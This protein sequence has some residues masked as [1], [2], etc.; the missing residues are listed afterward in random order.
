MKRFLRGMMVAAAL[1][2][3]MG[4]VANDARAANAVYDTI[5][6]KAEWLNTSRALTPEDLKG[7]IILLDFWTF[8]CINCMHVIPDLHYLEEKFGNKLTVIGV[9]SAKFT[10]E[11]DS[12]NIRNAM[13]RYDIHHPVVNDHDFGIWRAMGAQAWPTFM[14]I[15]PDGTIEQTYAGEGHREDLEED[16]QDLVVDAG[17]GLRVD[18]LPIALEKDE[19]PKTVLRF[20]GK[21]ELAP[22]FGG[23]PMLFVA[24]SGHHRVIGMRLDGKV[25]IEVGNGEVGLIDAALHQA[26]FNT[27]QGLLWDAKSNTLF[28]ADT[29]NHALRA[30][31]FTTKK[32]TTLAGDGKQGNIRFVDGADAKDTRLASPWDL[33]FYPDSDHILIAMAGTHQLWTYDRKSATLDVAAGNGR[34]SIE[35]GAWPANSLSQPS[36]IAI[37]GNTAYFVD[38]ETSSLRQLQNGNL[39]TLIGTGLF[40]FGYAE[41][42]KGKGLM[43]HPLGVTAQDGTVYVADSYN[44]AI[45][46][47]DIGSGELKNFAGT[48]GHGD[49]DAPE[50][51]QA[52]FNEPNDVLLH[53]GKLYVADTNNHKIRTITLADGVVESLEVMPPPLP[54]AFD[55]EIPKEAHLPDATVQAGMETA[56]GL[57]LAKGWKLN[58]QAPSYLALYDD[59]PAHPMVVVLEADT[60]RKGVPTLPVLPGG[61]SYI[62][63]GTLY[64]CEDKEGSLCLI[65]TLQMKLNSTADT[66]GSDI[67]IPINA[68]AQLY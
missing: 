4:M 59:T 37:L 54:V 23:K 64:Y 68:Q 57:S 58:D 2:A 35:D 52:Q 49:R 26:R 60:L 61:K 28:V 10:N 20:P 29:E 13:L 40:D 44:H 14:L 1:M 43:Q 7:R 41:G 3:G 62:L 55:N 18:A 19:A 46:I 22:D 50:A 8:C 21:L 27:P 30:I 65:K 11:R 48:G 16:I 39:K 25:E 6:S 66:A 12:A 53:S 32:V 36:G 34:E 5:T 47:F 24:D 17:D 51:A 63:Q 33:A 9:H 42:G 45:R 38:S 31:D 67:V 15:G 56:I